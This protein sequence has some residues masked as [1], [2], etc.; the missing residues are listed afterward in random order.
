MKRGELTPEQ[1]AGREKALEAAGGNCAKAAKA[2]GIWP[3]T[4]REW[5]KRR[6]RVR[7]SPVSVA[8]G[9][10][11]KPDSEPGIV[12]VGPEP[13]AKA[14]LNMLMQLLERSGIPIEEI[15]RVER[16]RINEWQGLSK[17]A[18][19]N[20]V[21]TDMHGASVILTPKWADGPAWPVIQQ[22]P[23]VTIKPTARPPKVA[24]GWKTAAILPD[25]QVGFYREGETLVPTHDESALAVALDIMS[26]ADPDVVVLV[27]DNLDLPEFGRYRQHP[28]FQRTT[29]AAIDRVTLLMAEIR[30]RIRPHAEI[31]YLAGN[32]EE[33]LP[34]YVIDNARAAFGLKR[35]NAPES[36]PVQSVPFL[37][38][39]DESRVTF[40]A[41]YPANVYWINESLRVIHGNK[42]RSG[43]STA[44]AYLADER[45]STIF[46]HVHRQELAWRTRNTRHGARSYMAA[47]PGCLC[48]IDGA[49]PGVSAGY[50]LEGVPLATAEDWQQG[51]AVVGFDPNGGRFDYEPIAIWQGWA[52]WRGREFT[53]TN[54]ARDLNLAG[55]GIGLR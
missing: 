3:T 51:A 8:Q 41:G 47:S 28:T 40:L 1:H 7:D 19:G 17:D 39:F 9:Q 33:R 42:V 25:I 18:D 36:W 29:Q 55:R 45:H 38:R 50:S 12:A 6:D 31:V 46:G 15:G 22:G 44:H 11:S 13:S 2:L 16:V 48:R 52:R 34:N 37:C 54:E 24:T 53:A 21:V 32:H 23:S 27:G 5:K 26:A 43:G 20:A 14:R 49:V 10:P 4:M 35:G 30:A